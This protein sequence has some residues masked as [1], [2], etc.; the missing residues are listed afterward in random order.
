MVILSILRRQGSLVVGMGRFAGQNR[1]TLCELFVIFLANPPRTRPSIRSVL[2]QL[3]VAGF[4][5]L[6]RD[7]MTPQFGVAELDTLICHGTKLRGR[8]LQQILVQRHSSL[9]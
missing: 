8:S 2:A 7:W 3:V 9:K 4:E 6:L 5:S 1:Q